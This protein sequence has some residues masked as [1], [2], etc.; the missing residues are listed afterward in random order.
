MLFEILGLD[1]MG[2]LEHLK[3]AKEKIKLGQAKFTLRV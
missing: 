1:L 2:L 3:S